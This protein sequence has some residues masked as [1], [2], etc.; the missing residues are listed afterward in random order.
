MKAFRSANTKEMI[1]AFRKVKSA[2]SKSIRLGN[3]GV[4]VRSDEE[5]DYLKANID[6]NA[7]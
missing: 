6:M 3:L 1:Q 7:V 5:W 2:G 4:F